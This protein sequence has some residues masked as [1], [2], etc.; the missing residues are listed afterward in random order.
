MYTTV[1][2]CSVLYSR[3]LDSVGP[4]AAWLPTLHN[5]FI[6]A[7]M[8]W[9]SQGSH[10]SIFQTPR[11]PLIINWHLDE[12]LYYTLICYTKAQN[13]KNSIRLIKTKTNIISIR[14]IPLELPVYIR[15]KHCAL[16]YDQ[17]CAMFITYSLNAWGLAWRRTVNFLWDLIG[18]PCLLPDKPRANSSHTT[19]ISLVFS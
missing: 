4:H 13:K 12:R 11:Q 15:N 5:S 8:S 17:Y 19:A 10:Q 2:I 7:I 9:S 1:H 6:E 3:D 16:C 14:V 18:L